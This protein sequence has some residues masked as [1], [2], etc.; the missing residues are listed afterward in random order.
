MAASSRMNLAVL[1][2]LAI[3][4]KGEVIQYVPALLPH[5]PITH[6]AAISSIISTCFHVEPRSTMT[7]SISNLDTKMT[8]AG[9]H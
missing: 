8:I 1:V 7:Y 3:P 5:C 4:E 9:K 6:R 2:H